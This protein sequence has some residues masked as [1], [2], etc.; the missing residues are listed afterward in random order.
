MMENTLLRFLA[1]TKKTVIENVD[2][3][4]IPA[5]ELLNARAEAAELCGGDT[6]DFSLYL[7]ACV[8]AKCARKD[9]K[10]LFSG[11]DAVLAALPAEKIAQWMERYQAACS[12][13]DPPCTEASRENLQTLLGENAYER[14]KWRVL[15]TFGVLPSEKRAQSMKSGDYLYC[16]MQMMLDEEDALEGMCPSCREKTGQA[17]CS[18]CGELLPERN[19]AFDDQRFEE[20]K[21]G[22]VSRRNHTQTE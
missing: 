11:G 18:V 4:F 8:L 19:A 16:V 1:R 22:D 14:L 10:R 3:Y 6:E 17:R 12:L 13:D 15:R 5:Q 9:G 7:N 2:F 21:R 20:L